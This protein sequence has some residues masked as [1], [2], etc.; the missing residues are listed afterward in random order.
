AADRR[1]ARHR[2]EFVSWFLVR[3]SHRPGDCNKKGTD[4]LEFRGSVPFLLQSSRT[5]AHQ[6]HRLSDKTLG[7]KLI[8]KTLPAR[9][10]QPIVG[11]VA[12]QF[13]EGGRRLAGNGLPHAREEL[14]PGTRAAGAR[15]QGGS[16]AKGRSRRQTRGARLEHARI[17]GVGVDEDVIWADTHLVVAGGVAT[18][19]AHHELVA[20]AGT[21]VEGH[22]ALDIAQGA[23]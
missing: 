20:L 17:Q 12:N 5:S 22:L 18:V 15:T 9:S 10:R 7:G 23:V 13:P 4:P 21:A 1:P 8:R 2:V 19:P 6:R 3:G 14:V 16:C 11:Q